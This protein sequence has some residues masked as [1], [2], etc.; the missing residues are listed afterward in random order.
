M[1]IS[2]KFRTFPWVQHVVGNVSPWLVSCPHLYCYVLLLHPVF[3]FAGRR[4][5]ASGRLRNFLQKESASPGFPIRIQLLDVRA[6]D[7][8]NTRRGRRL[9][10]CVSLKV[11]ERSAGGAGGGGGTG[12][13]GEGRNVPHS[14][15][16]SKSREARAKRTKKNETPVRRKT[17]VHQSYISCIF[18][19]W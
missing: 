1:E 15:V 11:R 18:C 2:L 9:E 6:M 10:W 4:Q 13:G 3:D 17:F 16:P 8:V 7:Y 5:N 14:L 12:R 19:L